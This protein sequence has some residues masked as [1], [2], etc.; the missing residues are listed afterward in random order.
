MHKAQSLQQT[1]DTVRECSSSPCWMHEVD[2]GYLGY[3]SNEE[4]VAFL[5]S[6]LERERI[7]TKA[8]ADIV[9]Q[10]TFV[11]PDLILEF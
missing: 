7:G 6:L 5:K 10:L 11:S 9:T 3:W 1:V 2:P 8:F 4:T